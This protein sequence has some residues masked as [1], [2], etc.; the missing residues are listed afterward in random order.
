MMER[1][2]DTERRRKCQFFTSSTLELNK[3]ERCEM[4]EPKCDYWW[5]HN[6]WQHWKWDKA[7]VSFPHTF[8]QFK[9]AKKKNKE[10]IDNHLLK[11]LI[12][13]RRIARNTHTMLRLS[14]RQTGFITIKYWSDQILLLCLSAA[15][16]I[17]FFIW[18]LQTTIYCF[19]WAIWEHTFSNYQIPAMAIYLSCSLNNKK[20]NPLKC[21]YSYPWMI[22][23]M[24]YSLCPKPFNL[25]WQPERCYCTADGRKDD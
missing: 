21:H 25:K 16:F 2:P 18:R 5:K 24:K 1:S 9:N 7:A 6:V 20:C 19:L 14:S 23:T 15:D 10:I 13:Y 22:T 17:W 12:R 8:L 3:V 4:V 11:M